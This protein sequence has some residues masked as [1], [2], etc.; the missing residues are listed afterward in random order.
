MSIPLPRQGFSGRDSVVSP[1]S[2]LYRCKSRLGVLVVASWRPRTS[3]LDSCGRSKTVILLR[4]S[5]KID[6]FFKSYVDGRPRLLGT[7]SSCSDLQFG[8]S[9]DPPGA[10]SI[11]G[12]ALKNWVPDWFPGFIRV[13]SGSKRARRDYFRGIEVLRAFILMCS[14]VLTQLLL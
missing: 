2:V 4:T 11:R 5:L 1:V 13:G 6:F 9:E 14:R 12:S 8:L 10:V 3:F 7:A